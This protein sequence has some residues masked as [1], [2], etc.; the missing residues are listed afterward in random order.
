MQEITNWTDL[1]IDSLGSFGSRIMG[2]I[3]SLM[4]VVII[5][6]GGYVVAR[7]VSYLISKFLKV[8]KFD[9]LAEKIHVSE[10]LQKANV[11]MTP[12]ELIG[13]FAYWILMLLV[14]IT[15]SETLG[16]DAVSREI[17]KI[18]A[19]MPRI[20]MA[21]V[22][23]VVGTYIAGFVRDVIAGATNSLGI[24][25]GKII[26]SAVFYLIFITVCLTALTQAGVD[27]TVITS[28]VLLILGAILLSAAISYG[29][30]SREV[31]SNVLAGFF[32][33]KMYAKGMKIEVDGINGK[34]VEITTIGVAIEEA[35]GDL[36]VVPTIK[37]IESNVRIINS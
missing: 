10:Y 35:N 6:L 9:A 27:T 34:I 23:F 4:G 36:V 37:F 3:P 17:S 31:L 15:A 21:I 13:K 18:L 2:V 24:S 14:L 12:S 20:F 33:K 16:W 5:F 11:S 30:A 22:L 19:Y 1:F 7:I 26:S 25:T 28:N 8:A 29:L 32:S